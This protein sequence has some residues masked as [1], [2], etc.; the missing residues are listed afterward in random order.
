MS[1]GFVKESDREE[2][3]VIPPRAPLPAGQTNYV[4]PFGYQQLLAEQAELEAGITTA[5]QTIADESERRIE[6]TVLGEKLR[7]LRERI[8]SAQVISPGGQ[9]QK[10]VRFGARVKLIAKEGIGGHTFQI[11]GVDEADVK[12]GKLSFTAPLARQITGKQ[13]GEVVELK[14]GKESAPWQIAEIEYRE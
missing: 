14:L 11:V 13:L 6:L 3:P 8:Q 7:L 5:N 12:A 2:L 4:T 10:E 9:P 1:R